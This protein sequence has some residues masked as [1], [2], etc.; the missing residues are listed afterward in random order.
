MAD[1]KH[2]TSFTKGWEGGKSNDP[3]DTASANPSPWMWTDPKTKITAPLHTNKGVTYAAFA[4]AAKEMGFANSKE[5]F[6]EMSD[7]IWLKIAKKKYWDILKLDTVNSQ[8][9]ANL[10][11]SWIWGSGY[12]WRAR[13]QRYLQGKGISWNINNFT[14][15]AASLNALSKNN[16][17]KIFEELIEQKKQY[18]LS[19]KGT[20]SNPVTE[21]KPQGVYTDGWLNRLED[22]KKTSTSFITEHKGGIAG[23]LF[24][25]VAA[26]AAYYYRDDIKNFLKKQL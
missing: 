20:K 18:L 3:K 11:F 16:E 19:L 7:D 23:G 4:A 14:A 12:A 10:M 24:F 1:I 8:A 21:K 2:I 9:I 5:N 13:M 15:L 6:F 25:L 22:L 26:G 17:K